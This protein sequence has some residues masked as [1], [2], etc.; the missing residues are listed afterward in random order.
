VDQPPVTLAQFPYQCEID[1]DPDKWVDRASAAFIA[2]LGLP[3]K[4]E[5]QWIVLPR[6]DRGGKRARVGIAVY[7]VKK[8][9]ARDNYKSI[10][11][12]LAA[13]D[14][15]TN[16][17]LSYTSDLSPD[18]SYRH[19]NWFSLAEKNVG[20][21]AIDAALEKKTRALAGRDI[22]PAAPSA[23]TPLAHDKK[24]FAIA[25]T[26]NGAHIVSVGFDARL[27]IWDAKTG[28]ATATVSAGGGRMAFLHAVSIARGDKT[29]VTG[30]RKLTI[31][32]IPDGRKLR[33]LAGHPNGEVYDARF[34]PSGA[35]IG[36]ISYANYTGG[37]NSVALWDAATGKEKLRFKMK[38]LLG[39][40]VAFSG[41]ERRL[42]AWAVHWTTDDP[43]VLYAFD[44]KTGKL[45]A[46][47]PL[48]AEV[49]RNV[50]AAFTATPAGL[51][52]AT[53]GAVFV[54]D[55]NLKTKRT[56]EIARLANPQ[57]RAAFS[58]DGKRI[59][60]AD[61]ETVE[62]LDLPSGKRRLALTSPL[63]GEVRRPTWSPDGDVILAAVETRIVRWNAKTGKPLTP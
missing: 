54:L 8:A 51:L 62:V 9:R 29:L 3:R 28:A 53:W 42:F 39:V 7:G 43:D 56:I 23:S 47:E 63:P 21:L 25:M 33:E 50:A 17:L 13:F 37:D 18:P 61:N 16:K 52:A 10:F 24:V 45:I 26:A 4:I 57:V 38:G 35:V 36:S 6:G 59:V 31:Y 40:R 22:R 30:P 41:D 20:Y 27:R 46:E 55:E 1:Y 44:T 32:S 12:G 15:K 49:A 19:Q 58:P 14:A 5:P 60:V 48:R 34:S 11:A 2:A